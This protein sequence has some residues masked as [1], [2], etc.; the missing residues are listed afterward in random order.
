MQKLSADVPVYQQIVD[1]LIREIAA[2]RLIDGERLPPERELADQ[3][4]I[5]VGTLR[6]SLNELENRGLLQ[7]IQG[8]GNYIRAQGPPDSTY[9][10][11]RLER[12][13]GGGLPSAKVLSVDR[14]PKSPELPKFGPSDQGHRILRQRYLSG[15][16]AAL[17]EIWLDALY[18]EKLQKDDLP[19]SMYLFYRKRLGISILQVEDRIGIEPC[20]A[21]APTDFPVSPGTL[22]PHVLRFGL[23]QD[24]TKVEISRTWYDPKTTRYVARHK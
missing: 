22:M 8:S 24:G 2:G 13:E 7:R 19:E 10:L 15:M 3:F 5:A 20:P 16:P 21:W 14:L 4:G 1:L 18:I 6:K 23:G 9:A 17:E 11:F 12:I